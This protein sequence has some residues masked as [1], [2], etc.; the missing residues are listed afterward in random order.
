MASSLSLR[1]ALTGYCENVAESRI[2]IARIPQQPCE[3]ASRVWASRC[4]ALDVLRDVRRLALGV[5]EHKKS[6]DRN[7]RT[8]GRELLSA[9]RLAQIVT[10]AYTLHLKRIPTMSLLRQPSQLT[11]SCTVDFKRACKPAVPKGSMTDS[12][13]SIETNACW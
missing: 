9:F 12:L 6:R 5:S 13:L 2:R 3:R 10:A 7:R 1:V 11:P 4:A 8:Y